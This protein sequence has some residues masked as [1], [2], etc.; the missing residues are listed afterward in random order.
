MSNSQ[1]LPRN[2]Y[3]DAQIN[4]FESSGTSS[5]RLQFS[6]TRNQPVIQ[7][8]GAY[9]ISI[10]RFEL[11]TYSLP[12]WIA[13]I[14]PEQADPNRMIETV[15]L[16]YIPSS[17]SPVNTG[18]IPLTWVPTNLHVAVPAG[19]TP[20]QDATTEYYWANSFR[21][22]ADLVSTALA[23]ASSNLKTAVGTD[24]DAFTSP[25]LE[26]DKTRQCA[27]LCGPA[28]F[29]DDSVTGDRVNIYFNRALYGRLTSLPAT[30]NYNGTSGMIYRI[31]MQ[32][33]H[34]SRLFLA[35]VRASD[36]VY[37]RCSQEY[38]TISNWA[39]AS[40]IVFTTNSIPVIGS[41]QSEPLV[42]FNGSAISTGIPQNSA[43]VISDMATTDLCYK[44]NL[45][46]VP[47]AEYRFMSLIGTNEISTIDVNV[48]WRDKKGNLNPFYLQSGASASIKILFRLK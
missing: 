17:G 47:S 31:Q 32:N 12:T 11:D 13:S 30:K 41:A 27:S 20:L 9:E 14:E 39:A 34:G 48:Y 15:T 6:E 40:S 46:Y 29:C 8:S 23:T 43:L 18:A 1:P 4:N 38:S 35:T 2:V 44:P 24:L 5:L 19:P 26:W 33:D 45:L 16:E 25:Y 36:I 10:V 28:A 37:V 22:Y 3:Y 42:Y 21:H 7:N